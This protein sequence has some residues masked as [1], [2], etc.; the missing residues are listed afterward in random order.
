MKKQPRYLQ[1]VNVMRDRITSGEWSIGNKLPT[2]RELAEQFEVNRSTIVTAIEILKSER[3]LESKTGSGIYVINNHQSLLS[4]STPPNWSNLSK[5]A[6]HPPREDIVR[7]INEYEGREGIIQLSRGELG[8]DL[9]PHLEISECFKNNLSNFQ[10]FDYGDGRGSEELR[11]ALS[12]YLKKIGIHASPSNILIVSGALQA[13]KLISLGVLQRNSTVFMESPSYIY[14]RYLFRS[15]GINLEAIPLLKGMRE[16]KEFF[17]QNVI[18]KLSTLYLNPTFHNP[19]TRIMTADQRNFIIERSEYFS[20]PIIENDVLRD[21]WIDDPPPPSLKALDGHGNVLYVNSFSKTIAPGLRIGWVVGPSDVIHRLSDLRMQIDYGCSFLSQLV[22]TELLTSGRYE[23]HLSNVR[24]QLR[25]KRDFLL[26]LL[27]EHFSKF[28]T[29]SKPKGG[30]FVWLVFKRKVNTRKLFKRCI[31]EGILLNP[32][33]IYNS[34]EPSLR[35]SFGY[36]TLEEMET[37]II[38]IRR[39]LE[40]EL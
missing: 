36:P 19:T 22:A 13:L 16:L 30:L 24:V 28:A 4:S 10:G 38:T 35:F 11:K 39:I 5:W 25:M 15:S 20:M 33:F 9:F 1:I 8:P 14:S 12:H 6:L 27:E 18:N 23:K 37:G 40:Q 3:L 26:S 34:R 7:I 31:H 17:T 29:W 2:Q 32:G 21:L